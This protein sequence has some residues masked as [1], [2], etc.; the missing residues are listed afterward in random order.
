[1]IKAQAM[2]RLLIRKRLPIHSVNEAPH[3]ADCSHAHNADDY[4]SDQVHKWE[5]EVPAMVRKQKGSGRDA[6]KGGGKGD[7]R[8]SRFCAN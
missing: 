2:R 5:Q 1:M 8:G 6:G 4:D 3:H 7:T